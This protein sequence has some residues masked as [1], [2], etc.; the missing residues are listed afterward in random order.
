MQRRQFNVI[1]NITSKFNNFK[2]G[3]IVRMR[4]SRCLNEIVG[5]FSNR[6]KNNLQR[7]C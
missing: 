7:W 1:K 6:A 4:E 2:H 5:R 3:L